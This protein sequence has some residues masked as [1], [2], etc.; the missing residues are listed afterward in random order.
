MS[1]PYSITPPGLELIK[2]FEG[3]DLEAYI[4]PV[5][6]P[7]IGYGRIVYP[8]GTK[9]RLG[10]DCTQDQ[11]DAWLLED[12]ENKAAKYVRNLK[13]VRNNLILWNQF[14][15]LVSFTFNRGAGRLRQL[16]EIPA[17]DLGDIANNLLSFNWAGKDKKVLEG[18]ERRRYAEKF[19]FEGRNW[20]PLKD[21]KNWRKFV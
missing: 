4:D 16:M 20:K 19:M 18:L 5:G 11:A 1:E 2:H 3:C 17:E 8:D 7:T 13:I 12:V 21:S 9:V 14:D 15:A 6:V 10:D